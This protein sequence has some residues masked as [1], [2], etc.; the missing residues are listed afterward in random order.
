MRL[1][2]AFSCTPV[3]V[4]AKATKTATPATATFSSTTFVLRYERASHD[5]NTKESRPVERARRA[6]LQEQ[7]QQQ[8][9]QQQRAIPIVASSIK[10]RDDLSTLSPSSSISKD[11]EMSMD[12]LERIRGI[13]NSIVFYATQR[14]VPTSSSCA[15][16]GWTK[17][18][19]YEEWT[20]AHT[21]STSSDD[22][23]DEAESLLH[24]DDEWVSFS[25]FSR[26]LETPII[27]PGNPLVRMNNH[28]RSQQQNNDTVSL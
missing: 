1:Y 21:T 6:I 16:N 3:L 23:D 27:R 4:T 7:Q 20:A 14:R 24:D 12:T 25:G 8:Q 11:E 26:F 9:Q 19:N 10:K 17:P 15:A 2:S 13:P 18:L 22:A 28:N 5:I